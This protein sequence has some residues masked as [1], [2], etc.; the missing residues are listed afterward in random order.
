MKTGL[1]KAASSE[2]ARG[3]VIV[4]IGTT[5]RRLDRTVER[6]VR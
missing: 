3:M 4:H 1:A 6:A 5:A 2:S